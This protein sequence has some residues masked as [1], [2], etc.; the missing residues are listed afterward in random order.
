[1]KTVKAPIKPYSEAS[2][3]L[4][5]IIPDKRLI[6]CCPNLSV[7]LHKSEMVVLCFKEGSV[8]G[9]FNLPFTIAKVGNISLIF[10]LFN[11]LVVANSLR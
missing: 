9:F 6:T 1:M 11:E 4:I 3:I 2:R 8:M 7:K 5:K 10:N